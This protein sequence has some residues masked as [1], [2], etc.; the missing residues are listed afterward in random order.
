M[1][2]TVAKRI[3]KAVYAPMETPS[4]IGRMKRAID[5]KEK[6]YEIVT[7]VKEFFTGKKDDDGNEIKGKYTSHTRVST[8]LRHAYQNAKREYLRRSN[9]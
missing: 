6:T 2:G 9:G 3:R 4:F 1:R 8:G 5:M 7:T